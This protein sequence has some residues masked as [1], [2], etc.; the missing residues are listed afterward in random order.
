MRQIKFKGKRKDNVWV[1][2]SH[3]VDANDNHYILSPLSDKSGKDFWN[4]KF[5]YNEVL[6]ET[7][8]Q[9]TGLTDKNGKEVFEGDL[10]SDEYCGD[11]HEEQLHYLMSYDDAEAKFVIQDGGYS[12][13]LG[14]GSQDCY[15]G[16]QYTDEGRDMSQVSEME[17][18]GSIH[19]KED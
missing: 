15:G 16:F 1:F 6:P 12:H 8:S 7:I 11:G 19:D 4:N 17:I 2:G 5:Q 9:S 3:V 10:L 18:I 13:Y 14:E